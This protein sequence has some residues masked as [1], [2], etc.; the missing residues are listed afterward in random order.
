MAGYKA[1]FNSLPLGTIQLHVPMAIRCRVL[2]QKHLSIWRI[3]YAAV[4][5]ASSASLPSAFGA[6]GN[7]YVVMN[8]KCPRLKIRSRKPEKV[9]LE[10]VVRTSTSKEAVSVYK[11]Q[12][13]ILSSTG[14]S[15]IFDKKVHTEDIIQVRGAKGGQTVGNSLFSGASLTKLN[16]FEAFFRFK[17][18]KKT[19]NIQTNQ[20]INVRRVTKHF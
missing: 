15:S 17:M 19:E 5:A 3:F 16:N 4:L 11:S 9:T 20:P 6:I 2:H 7:Q 1:T 13:I 12:I 18:I 10:P 14:T 8:K